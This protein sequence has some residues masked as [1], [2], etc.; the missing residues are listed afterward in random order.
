M[1][2]NPILDKNLECIGIYNPQLVQDILKITALTGS[3]ELVKTNLGEPNLIHNGLP[4]HSQ[5]GAE[6]EAKGIFAKIQNSAL[7]IHIVYGLGLGYLFKEFCENSKGK[8]IL[9]EPNLEIL[10]A[11]LELVDFSKELSQPNVKVTSEISN[12]KEIFSREYTYKA[13]STISFLVSYKNNYK[14]KI[15]EFFKEVEIFSGICTADYNTLKMAI[16]E[17]VN[18]TLENFI[19]TLDETPLWE[20]KDSYKG[21]TALIVSA[22]PSLDLNIETIKANRDKFIIFCVGTALKALMKNGIKPDF[23]NILEVHDCSSQVAGYDLSDINLILEPYTHNIFHKLKVKQKFIFP[24]NSGHSSIWWSKITGVDISPYFAKGTVSYEALCSAK[25][26]GF[27]K[28]I[29]VGQDLAYVNNQCYS[30]DAAYSELVYDVNPE[31]KKVQ[32]KINDYEKY[33]Q[34]LIPE[35]GENPNVDYRGF[36]S[37]KITNLNDT[38]YFVKGVKGDML[39]TQG[40]YATFIEHFKDFASKNPDLDLINSSMI[41][42]N[43]EGFKNISLEDSIKETPFILEKPNLSKQNRYYDK[44]SIFSSLEREEVLL[45]EILKEFEQAR[46]YIFKYDREFRRRRTLSEETNK[47]LKLLLNLYNKILLEYQGN[48]IL[49]QAISFNENLEVQFA[50]KSSENVNIVEI[51]NVYEQLKIYFYMVEEKLTKTI[52]KIQQQKGKV[53]ESINST[54]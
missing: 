23:L 45:K 37:Y 42:A 24:T 39:P 28:I 25:M 36:A 17:S 54:G 21:K 18:S 12:F 44:Q 33:I 5:E 50:L 49:Y 31:T 27:S 47:Y 46:E 16:M 32:I 6:A 1:S 52:E 3:F 43:I 19:Y 26:L 40:G 13:K 8:V 53:L 38:L 29:L 4:I 10:R 34:S 20:I 35:S 15:D 30:K 2:D 51:Q 9:F 11:T 7:S 22:G 41:G 48:N 14:N